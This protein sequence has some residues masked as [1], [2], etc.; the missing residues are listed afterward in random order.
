M[1]IIH[2]TE[3]L[4]DIRAITTFGLHAKPNTDSPIGKFG[5]GLKYAIATLLRLECK[6]RV[7][8]GEVEYEFFTK[9]EDFRGMEFQQVYMKKRKGL[10]AKWQSI[11]LPF[12]TLHGKHWEPWQAFRELESNTRDEGGD[13]WFEVVPD[14]DP[15][16]FAKPD[17]TIISVE[18]EI[19]RQA[20]L[21][22]DKIFLPN[23]LTK[24]EGDDHMQVFNEPSNHIYWRGIRVFD[25]EKP[26]IYTYNIL[27][28]VTLTEDRTMKYVWD[29][30]SKIA[31]YVARSKD[32]KMINAIVSAETEK[33]FEGRLDFDYAYTSPSA[34]FIEVVS[35]K[36]FRGAYVAPRALIYHDRY[37]PKVQSATA[38]IK[39]RIYEW[40]GNSDIPK[41][42]D[43]LLKHLMRCEIKEPDPNVDNEIPF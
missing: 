27:D 10:L 22:I 19:Y 12:T 32:R 39:E 6:V 11:E 3:G 18:G 1:S 33:H 41:E 24:R 13:T 38:T 29:A 37:A 9:S 36:K 16:I 28:D 30:Q 17:N 40:V 34:E 14:R 20:F 26:S 2:R 15:A 43:E 21:D 23:A 31:A 25:L 5:T 35:K 4:L 7:F 8:I 42:L